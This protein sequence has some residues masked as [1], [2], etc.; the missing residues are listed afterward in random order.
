MNQLRL[1]TFLLFIVL[2]IS[3]FSQTYSERHAPFAIVKEKQVDET[4]QNKN[5]KKLMKFLEKYDNITILKYNESEFKIVA[6]GVTPYSND[7]VLENVFLSK[8]ANLRTKGTITFQIQ[9]EIKKDGKIEV[10]F[11]DFVHEAFYSRYGEISFGMILS[12]EKVPLNKCYEHT[13]WCNA[14]WDEIKTKMRRHSAQIW[15]DIQQEFK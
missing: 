13:L 6:E 12:N 1:F 2:P 7:V 8:D 4:S 10:V 5:F 14:V 9:A 3:V 15:L 11:T